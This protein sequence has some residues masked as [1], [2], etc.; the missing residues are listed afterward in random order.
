VK[1]FETSVRFRLS[2]GQMFILW[3]GLDLLITLHVARQSKGGIRYEFPFR[4]YPPPVGF[5]RGVLDQQMMDDIVALWQRLYPKSKTGGR[6]RMNEAELRAVIFG[7]RAYIGFDRMRRRKDRISVKDADPAIPIDDES[8]LQLKVRS[9]R[10]VRS[11]GRHLK[12]ASR[13]L[14]KSVAPERHKALIDTWR[15]HQRWMHLHIVYFQPWPKVIRGRKIGQQKILDALTE[16]AGRGIRNA[17]YEPPEP[18]E[19]RRMMRPFAS[20]A[21]RFREGKYS[22]LRYLLAR[23]GFFEA[24]WYLAQFV[25]N[26]LKLKEL[27]KS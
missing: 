12:Q 26:R 27:S 1:Q 15:K 7:N 6:M 25:T 23:K 16:M 11:L 9:G 17:G 2:A 8:F 21:R 14:S 5:D 13:A 20:S 18:T 10:V 22:D 3:L 4:I 19:L 24:T